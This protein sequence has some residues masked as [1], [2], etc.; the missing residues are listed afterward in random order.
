M[1]QHLVTADWN[2]RNF[3]YANVPLGWAF[4]VLRA[5]VANN[6]QG[7]AE[8]LATQ[9]FRADEQW[10]R[11]SQ[12]DKTVRWLKRLHEQDGV[13]IARAIRRAGASN[14]YGLRIGRDR[15]RSTTL[16]AE[17]GL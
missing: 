3:D 10:D 15:V 6:Q 17:L 1:L 13:V 2:G 12:L 8:D 16:A 4:T 14:Y 5:L 11:Y 7:A 9:F